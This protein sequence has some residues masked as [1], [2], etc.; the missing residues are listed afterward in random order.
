[1]NLIHIFDGMRSLGLTRYSG[2]V[3]IYVE[4]IRGGKDEQNAKIELNL[5]DAGDTG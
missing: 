5:A 1:M 2:D 3:V 4:R